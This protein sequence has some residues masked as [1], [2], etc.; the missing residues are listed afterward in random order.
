MV[1]QSKYCIYKILFLFKNC[2]KQNAIVPITTCRP[3]TCRKQKKCS[4]NKSCCCCCC[5]S[6]LDCVSKNSLYKRPERIIIFET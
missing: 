2:L 6:C 4:R 5:Y 3:T 1:W